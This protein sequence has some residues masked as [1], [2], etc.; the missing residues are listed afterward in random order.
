MYIYISLNKPATCCCASFYYIS[1]SHTLDVYVSFMKYEIKKSRIETNKATRAP[2]HTSSH[3]DM[4]IFHFVIFSCYNKIIII[5]FA[6]WELNWKGKS[7]EINQ[8]STHDLIYTIRCNYNVKC[9]MTNGLYF[10]ICYKIWWNFSSSSSYGKYEK[11][12]FCYGSNFNDIASTH[13]TSFE[14][15]IIILQLVS[16]LGSHWQLFM[17]ALKSFFFVSSSFFIFHLHTPESSWVVLYFEWVNVWWIFIKQFLLFFMWKMVQIILNSLYSL[18]FLWW[19]KNQSGGR[20]GRRESEKG[21]KI[22]KAWL[23]C[24]HFLIDS[25]FFLF[26]HDYKCDVK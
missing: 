7:I 4:M 16:L 23:H 22:T 19:K 14:V 6:F 18:S 3:N 11:I 9:Q 5:S 20:R 25:H 13:I 26:S 24:L 10:M 1:S 17:K 2:S 15:V 12:I 21:S 8:Q